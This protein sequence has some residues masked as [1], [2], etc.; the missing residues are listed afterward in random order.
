MLKTLTNPHTPSKKQAIVFLIFSLSV[1]AGLAIWELFINH[2]T[3]VLLADGPMSAYVNGDTIECQSPPCSITLKP[4]QYSVT[5]RRAG[6]FDDTQSI[7]VERFAQT[8]ITAR[9]SVVPTIKKY[10]DHAIPSSFPLSSILS[11]PTDL[12][13]FPK[14]A[15]RAIFSPSAQQAIVTI[16]SKLGLYS[17]K[18]GLVS[19]LTI[20]PQTRFSWAGESIVFIGLDADK[21]QTIYLYGATAD[22]QIVRFERA[23]VAPFVAAD[24]SGDFLIVSDLDKEKVHYL[25]DVKNLSKKRIPLNT[26]AE[27]LG[28]ADGFAIFSEKT[29]LN[30]TRINAVPLTNYGT[31]NAIV[32]P[33]AI[34]G[35]VARAD[36]SHLVYFTKEK[37]DINGGASQTSIED[38]ISQIAQISNSDG[39]VSDA[40]STDVLDNIN[41]ESRYTVYLTELDIATQKTKTLLSIPLA[42]NQKII[43]MAN[44]NKLL[45]LRIE[46]EIFEI[47]K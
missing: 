29:T 3:L 22:T 38:V 30:E 15:T 40:S 47:V 41:K 19:E 36:D 26:T 12:P 35:I 21:T 2:G 39:E 37:T 6:Y 28:F 25:V 24:P 43:D 13:N 16:D 17:A 5:F 31:E 27:L 44:V 34:G 4:R 18:T 45:L 9:F 14:A 46:K 20:T 23:L 10:V 42:E 11:A 8:P 7:N 33:K 32:L 1:A